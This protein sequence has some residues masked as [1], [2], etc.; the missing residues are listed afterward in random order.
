MFD[1]PRE[2]LD[3][4]NQELLCEEDA[5]EESAEYREDPDDENEIFGPGYNYA[6]DFGR[7]VFDDEEVPEEEMVYVE[8]NR[9]DNSRGLRY[10]LFLEIIGILAVIGWWLRWLI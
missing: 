5:Y 1:D 3:W 10:L 4:L 7:T 6:V 8:D 2:R 9:G